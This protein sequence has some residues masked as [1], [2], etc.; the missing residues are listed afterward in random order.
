LAKH[1]ANGG[2]GVHHSADTR[3]ANYKGQH[4]GQRNLYRLQQKENRPASY[5]LLF[6][7][8]PNRPA[9]IIYKDLSS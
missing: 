2:S 1:L 4:R 6:F 7:N 9:S 8:W 5:S 3:L